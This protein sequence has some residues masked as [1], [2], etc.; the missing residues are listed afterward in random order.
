MKH[1]L[2]TL[3]LILFIFQLASTQ[4]VEQVKDTN[5]N[6]IFPSGRFYIKPSIFGAAGGGLKLGE[7][8]NSTCPL[9]VLQD[10]SELKFSMV[11]QYNSKFQE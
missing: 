6:P 9:I 1:V 2:F 5:G 10:Y 3:S 8:N 11:Y 4:D 7:K